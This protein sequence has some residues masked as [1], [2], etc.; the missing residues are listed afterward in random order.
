M[1]RVK[2]KDGKILNGKI[3]W[4]GYLDIDITVAS[5]TMHGLAH[6]LVAYTFLEYNGDKNLIKYDNRLENVMHAVTNGIRT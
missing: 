5:N 6:R 2:Q 4:N 3:T 1:G